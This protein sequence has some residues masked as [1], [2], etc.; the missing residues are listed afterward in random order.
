MVLPGEERPLR[1]NSAEHE[2]SGTNTRPVCVSAS[3]RGSAPES[4]N[5][6]ARTPGRSPKTNPGL[7]N[8]IYESREDV[9]ENRGCVPMPAKPTRRRLL[10]SA[11]AASLP[12]CL[13]AMG[14]CRSG[15]GGGGSRGALGFGGLGRRR[16]GR[17]RKGGGGKWGIAAECP[18]LSDN[19]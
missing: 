4:N 9:G 18:P 3:L 5:T 11:A 10:V 2:S 12:F 8:Q 19:K 16:R 6:L 14:G 15:G 17:W 1:L 7:E 13:R